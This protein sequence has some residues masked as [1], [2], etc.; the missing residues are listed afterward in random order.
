VIASACV[1]NNYIDRNIDKKMDRTSGRAI[2]A[3]K[4]SAAAALTYASLLGVIGFIVLAL[5]TNWLVFGLGL[6]ALVFYVALYGIAKRRSVHGTL[7]GSIPGAV[8]PAAGYL[9][10]TNHI[11]TAAILLFFVLVF[12]QM[13]HFY[14]IVM[15][16]Y[17]DYKAAGL[18]VFPI[19]KG[20]RAARLYILAYILA[21][22]AAMASLS[23]FGYTG[24]IY[25]GVAILLG[26]YWF[27]TGFSNYKLKD[28]LW[29]RRMFLVSLAINLGWSIM[30]AFGGRLP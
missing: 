10:V 5:F 29:G 13:P 23:V 22:T 8:P 7:V 11:D 6:A 27:Y 9:A 30:T 26:G 17:K 18:P 2:A 19:V 12:W 16:R 1:T 28:E 24:Y 15:Y 25:L 21:F 4:V 14:A 20:M 3:G